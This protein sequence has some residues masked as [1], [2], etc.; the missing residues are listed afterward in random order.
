[1]SRYK[2]VNDRLKHLIFWNGGSICNAIHMSGWQHQKFTC[3]ESVQRV[4]CGR[5]GC[6]MYFVLQFN[7]FYQVPEYNVFC[8]TYYAYLIASRFVFLFF[9]NFQAWVF[10]FCKKK[11]ATSSSKTPRS[12]A[13]TCS[14]YLIVKPLLVKSVDFPKYLYENGYVTAFCH[15]QVISVWMK[16]EKN[17][18]NRRAAPHETLKPSRPTTS[19]TQRRQAAECGAEPMASPGTRGAKKGGRHRHPRGAAPCRAQA[20]SSFVGDSLPH[21]RRRRL[22]RGPRSWGTEEI[23]G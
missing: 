23:G 14:I 18:S 5:R 2:H 8:I 22:G 4:S 16:K 20:E 10:K 13:A 21:R 3:V 17:K 1:M 19:G 12:I 15:G 9:L 7:P 6:I 11:G